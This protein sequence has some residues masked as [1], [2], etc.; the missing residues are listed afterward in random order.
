MI[1]FE[2]YYEDYY[3]M[4]TMSGM[5]FQIL[6]QQSEHISESCTPHCMLH[7]QA[8]VYINYNC[9]MNTCIFFLIG[10]FTY[11]WKVPIW[12]VTSVHLSN[13][14][15]QLNSHWTDFCEISYWILSLESVT[16]AQ[17]WLIS[18]KNIRHFTQRHKYISFLLM[19]WNHHKIIFVQ[20]HRGPF[21]AF[22]W[23]SQYLYF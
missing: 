21:A 19:I 15:D 2:V 13:C 22:P 14:M 11:L 7:F 9:I 20:Q 23:C 6:S 5:I 4:Q 1:N 18:D 16:N 3:T 12:F 17:I 10:V 8:C